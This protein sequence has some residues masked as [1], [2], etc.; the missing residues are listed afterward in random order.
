MVFRVVVRDPETGKLKY[1]QLL[2]R[3]KASNGLTLAGDQAAAVGRLGLDMNPAV[4]ACSDACPTNTAAAD[5]LALM[6]PN[7]FYRLC[8][9]P[10]TGSATRDSSSKI[11]SKLRLRERFIAIFFP[12]PMLTQ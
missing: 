9:T 10:G 1:I 2:G 8:D 7:I 12:P 4:C 6:Y 5:N 3:L 11:S